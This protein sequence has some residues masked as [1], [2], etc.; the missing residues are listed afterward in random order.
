[1]QNVKPKIAP[2]WSLRSV[3]AEFTQYCKSVFQPNAHKSDDCCKTELLY[4]LTGR[5]QIFTTITW[6]GNITVQNCVLT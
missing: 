1:M 6:S 3:R 4:L 5:M 2:L